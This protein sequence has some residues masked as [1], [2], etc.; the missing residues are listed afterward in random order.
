MGVKFGGNN[1]SDNYCVELLLRGLNNK[2]KGEFVKTQ[3]IK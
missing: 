1:L 3:V 2:E